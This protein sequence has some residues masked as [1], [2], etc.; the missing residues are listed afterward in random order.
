[1]STKG[2]SKY[3]L[4]LISTIKELVEFSLS[5]AAPLLKL[6]LQTHPPYKTKVTKQIFQHRRVAGFRKGGGAFLKV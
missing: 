4:V 6:R 5:S 1:M 2:I 3:L